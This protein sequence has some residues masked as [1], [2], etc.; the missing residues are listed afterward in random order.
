MRRRTSLASICF[1][2]AWME[3]LDAIA[4]FSQA[5]YLRLLPLGEDAKIVDDIGGR[6]ERQRSGDV[7]GEGDDDRA[8]REECPRRAMTSRT[9]RRRSKKV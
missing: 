5:V 9:M 3:D 1:L 6:Y 4:V 8:G 2:D 7:D